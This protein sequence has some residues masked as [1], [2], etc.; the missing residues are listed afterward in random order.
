MPFRARSSPPCYAHKVGYPYTSGRKTCSSH[1]LRS[2]TVRIPRPAVPC[3]CRPI[4][5][6][7]PSKHR[8]TPQRAAGECPNNAAAVGSECAAKGGPARRLRGKA[9]SGLRMSLNADWNECRSPC[10]TEWSMAATASLASLLPRLC[11]TPSSS[12]ACGLEYDS[13]QQPG[14]SWKRRG[15]DCR[16]TSSAGTGP[17]R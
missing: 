15:D 8:R 14:S 10:M 5:L 2:S 17:R 9:V 16:R 7:A 11:P 13:S 4:R 3:V 12:A 6:P 1:V